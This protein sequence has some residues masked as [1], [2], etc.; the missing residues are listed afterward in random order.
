MLQSR[1]VCHA[2][3]LESAEHLLSL[4]TPPAQPHAPATTE[5]ASLDNCAGSPATPARSLMATPHHVATMREGKPQ[6]TVAAHPVD[7]MYLNAVAISTMLM[8]DLCTFC[9]GTAQY[10]TEQRHQRSTSGALLMHQRLACACTACLCGLQLCLAT[11]T[12]KAVVCEAP[13]ECEQHTYLL[14]A[15]AD[16]KRKQRG[17]RRM[18]TPTDLCGPIQTPAEETLYWQLYVDPACKN[19]DGSDNFLVMAGRFNLQWG[20]QVTCIPELLL[21]AGSSV[22][23]MS[24]LFASRCPG[25]HKNAH[26]TGFFKS[27]S[28]VLHAHGDGQW[29]WCPSLRIPGKGRTPETWS[30]TS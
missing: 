20:I 4:S 18:L 23:E 13:Q 2:D 25:L 27:L 9:A 12:R 11:A 19:R 17:P 16:K 26:S 15:I 28:D 3:V 22:L 10:A 1:G 29:L 5:G 30:P 21:I 14:I 6:V 8:S 7:G 24:S